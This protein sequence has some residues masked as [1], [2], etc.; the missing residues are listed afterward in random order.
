[1][2][3]KKIIIIFVVLFFIFACEDQITSDCETAGITDTNMMAAKFSAIQENIFNK[4]CTECHFGSMPSGG[5]DLS[6]GKAY[7][8]LISSGLVMPGNSGASILFQRLSSSNPD[9]RM[10]PTGRLEQVLV[11][12]VAA[13]I[14]N[15]ALNN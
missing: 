15:G 7:S 11:D 13:W 12:S 14:D 10:P 6:E 9:F 3:I 8:E 4:R 1:M 5:L 2:I